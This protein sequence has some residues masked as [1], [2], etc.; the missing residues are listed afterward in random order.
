MCN[1][2][3]FP[4]SFPHVT[5]VHLPFPNT[6]SMVLTSVRSADPLSVWL[7]WV[8]AKGACQG[9]RRCHSPDVPQRKARVS[10]TPRVRC[11][12][13]T[14]HTAD[15]QRLPL[16][17]VALRHVFSHLAHPPMPGDPVSNS[18]S[19]GAGALPAI[20]IGALQHRLPTPP[21]GSLRTEAGRSAY[22]FWG[23]HNL[24]ITRSPLCP[25][26]P[27][28]LLEV[29]GGDVTSHASIFL[30]VAALRLGVE[31]AVYDGLL[32]PRALN[33][34]E[35][36]GSYAWGRNKQTNKQTQAMKASERKF[37]AWVTCPQG[38]PTS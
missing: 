24:N 20:V 4:F 3:K 30:V 13:R 8:P 16:R 6:V 17:T 23:F 26:A 7:V 10:A 25:Q 19:G 11:R 21:A 37:L 27:H 28:L 38:K 5:R 35:M 15:A 2:A 29:H 1:A 22:T 9:R 34:I 18:G 12:G 14:W 31:L 32:I 33:F 36:D